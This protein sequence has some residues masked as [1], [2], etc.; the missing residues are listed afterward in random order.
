MHVRERILNGWK[1]NHRPALRH[2]PDPRAN[3][4]RHSHRQ[5]SAWWE[6]AASHLITVPPGTVY[7]QTGIGLI[8]C[9]APLG[10]GITGG[11][12]HG[13]VQDC[14]P[15]A[16]PATSRCLSIGYRGNTT[17][18]IGET[19]P[20]APSDDTS[21]HLGPGSTL[22][23]RQLGDVRCRGRGARVGRMHR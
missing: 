15:L 20:T 21:E 16:A 1:A 2:H 19:P 11:R 22:R 12:A 17:R 8:V 7:P 9:L 23:W 14:F 10:A 6:I 13:L 5:A 3:G 4:P 18:S